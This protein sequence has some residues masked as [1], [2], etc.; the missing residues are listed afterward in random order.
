MRKL[1]SYKTFLDE[2]ITSFV[3]RKVVNRGVQNKVNAEIKPLKQ[4]NKTLKTNLKQ[5]QNMFKKQ[6]NK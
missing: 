5:Q 2:G 6:L 1:I 4:Q 3:A